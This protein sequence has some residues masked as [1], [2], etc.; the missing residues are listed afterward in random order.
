MLSGPEETAAITSE[1]VWLVFCWGVPESET[2]TTTVLVPADDGVPEIAPVELLMVRFA[3]KPEA[4]HLR[5]PVPPV[6]V[7]GAE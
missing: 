7:M 1:Y 6:A 3:G 2:D 5:V 4:D